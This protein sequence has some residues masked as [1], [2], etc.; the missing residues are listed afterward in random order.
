MEEVAKK[1][2]GLSVEMKNCNNLFAK[3][4]PSEKSEAVGKKGVKT[5]RNENNTIC[6]T[7]FRVDTFTFHR[8]NALFV[9][10]AC[11]NLIPSNDIEKRLFSLE[12]AFFMGST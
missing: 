6:K 7:E 3:K 11:K 12:Q 4:K 8:T 5:D 9:L 2:K 1:N 10:F